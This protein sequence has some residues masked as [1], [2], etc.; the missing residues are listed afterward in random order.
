MTA[1][2]NNPI[3]E[4]FSNCC[5]DN[6]KDHGFHESELPI[7]KILKVILPVLLAAGCVL[8][9][10]NGTTLIGK[11]F[12]AFQGDEGWIPPA[13]M[14]SSY[15][16]L[17]CILFLNQKPQ[18]QKNSNS[19][20]IFSWLKKIPTNFVIGASNLPK[21]LMLGISVNIIA[22]LIFNYFSINASAFADY[23]IAL[24]QISIFECVLKG[25]F[26]E[27]LFFR[28]F[29][30]GS[31]ISTMKVMNL[32]ASRMG[33][34]VT[35]SDD[36]INTYSRAFGAVTFGLAHANQ[37]LIQAASAGVKSYFHYTRLY[38]EKG[39]F[40]SYGLHVANNLFAYLMMKV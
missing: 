34:R 27:E 30:Q 39:L 29:V 40:A 36:T 22:K 35:I 12:Q 28:E 18:D 21:S 9:Q 16:A 8:Q 7:K 20:R 3:S 13:V 37:S 10:N 19:N 4:H 2:A 31:S 25:P 17:K 15:L 23:N 11:T 1:L 33:K 6:E 14:I 24:N 32:I 38:E 5:V 26:L